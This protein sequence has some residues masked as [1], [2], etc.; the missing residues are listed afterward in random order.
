MFSSSEDEGTR[1]AATLRDYLAARYTATI[2]TVSESSSGPE[3]HAASVF[4]VVGRGLELIFL[5]RPDS[6]HGTDLGDRGKAAFTVTDS[7]QN[8]KEIQG[9][10]LWGEVEKLSGR[11]RLE[12]LARYSAAFPFLREVSL[13]ARGAAAL[14]AAA[15]YRFVP[16][17]AAFT[18]NRTGLFGR[19]LLELEPGFPSSADSPS[20]GKPE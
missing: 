1:L 14:R 18:D 8:W 10:Q 16:F 19:V 2:A 15:A 20:D 6:R 3:P 4:Y 17:R 5:S 11:A 9:A 12:A 13:D 7:G